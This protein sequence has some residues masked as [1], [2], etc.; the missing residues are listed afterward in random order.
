MEYVILGIAIFIL[1]LAAI[2]ILGIDIFRKKKMEHK[3]AP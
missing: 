1:L 3:P 2:P